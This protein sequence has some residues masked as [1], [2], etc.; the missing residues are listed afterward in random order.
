VQLAPPRPGRRV[1]ERVDVATGVG[2]QTENAPS[3][4]RPQGASFNN[5]LL[6]RAREL[7]IPMARRAHRVYPRFSVATTRL[8]ITFMPCTLRRAPNYMARRVGESGYTRVASF[9]FSSITLR[10]E[11]H[12]SEVVG[13]FSAS[14]RF[15]PRA[16]S[17]R[18]PLNG[19]RAKLRAEG[20]LPPP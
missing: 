8:L 3:I 6:Y 11:G 5:T 2:E 1:P 17:G 18:G 7:P 9:A 15:G 12:A 16:V 10:A 13:A 19:P 14:V 20:H 4:F